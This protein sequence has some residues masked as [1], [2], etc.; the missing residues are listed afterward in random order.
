MTRRTAV[1]ITGLLAGIAV[2]IALGILGI[3]GYWGWTVVMLVLIWIA[4]YPPARRQ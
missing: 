1:H 4:L 3:P 2:I